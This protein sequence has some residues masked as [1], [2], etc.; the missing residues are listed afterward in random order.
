MFHNSSNDTSDLDEVPNQ[1]GGE[2]V[3]DPLYVV[4]PMTCVYTLILVS[5]IVGNVSTCIVI[6]TNKHMHTA[7]N[8]Y[9]CSLAMSDLLLLVTGLPVE[10]YHIWSR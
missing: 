6:V 8:F 2:V 3:R 9:L 7:T 5:G 4:V 10:M 1:W